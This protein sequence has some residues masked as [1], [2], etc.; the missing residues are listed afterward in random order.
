M[1]ILGLALLLLSL[2][3]KPCTEHPSHATSSSVKQ[4]EIPL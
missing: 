1:D 2:V 4:M 3:E